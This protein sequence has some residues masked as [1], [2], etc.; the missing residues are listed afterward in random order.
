MIIHLNGWP[1]VGKQTVGRLLAARLNARFIHNHVLHDVAIVCTG[2]DADR[3]QLYEA[4]RRLA[5]DYLRN[6]P[7]SDIFVMTNALCTNSQ[8]EREAWTHVVELAIARRVP[9]VPVVLEA[10]QHENERRLQS[11]DRVGRK[12]TDPSLL[13]S[14]LRVD[15]IQR[16]A[17]PEL[18]VVDTTAMSAGEAAERIFRHLDKL[19]EGS[20]LQVASEQHLRMLAN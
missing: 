1:G 6:R 15:S 20:P 2:S 14:F 17:V 9:L 18:L 12:L 11:D 8:R 16:P 19:K 5:Y 7:R 13:R 10:D 3:W 4:V